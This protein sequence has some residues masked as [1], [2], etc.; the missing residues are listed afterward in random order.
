MIIRVVEILKKPSVHLGIGSN[1][2]E[3]IAQSMPRKYK[4]T[5]NSGNWRLLVELV[6]NYISN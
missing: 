5:I 2:A 1:G 4:T 6:D 3:N